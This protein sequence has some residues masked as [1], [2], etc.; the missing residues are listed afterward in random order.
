VD[1]VDATELRIVRAE[2]LLK[3]ER[4]AEAE[5][6]LDAAIEKRPDHLHAYVHRCDARRLQVR[7]RMFLLSGMCSCQRRAER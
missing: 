7:L 5:A 4:H 6:D 3:L 1:D 2:S